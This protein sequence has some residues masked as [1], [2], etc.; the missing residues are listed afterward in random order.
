MT[1]LMFTHD[2]TTDQVGISWSGDR[3][4]EVLIT[5]DLLEDMM[6]QRNEAATTIRDQ[7][8]RIGRLEM[9]LAIVRLGRRPSRADWESAQLP[10]L[11]QEARL[12]LLARKRRPTAWTAPSR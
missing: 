10:P 5:M 8:E 2:A 3:P 7:K 6:R 1:E 4:T 12:D 11:T 9:L